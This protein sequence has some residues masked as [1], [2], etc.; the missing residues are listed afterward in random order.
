[1]GA[2][3]QTIATYPQRRKPLISTQKL[4]AN[5]LEYIIKITE[6]G[7]NVWQRQIDSSRR[8]N[9][10]MGRTSSLANQIGAD[11]FKWNNIRQ[12]VEGIQQAMDTITAPAV[13]FE[14]A[15]AELEGITGVTGKTLEEITQKSRALASTFGTDAANGASTFTEI[16]SRLGTDISKS[17]Q[18]LDAMGR[19]TMILSKTMQG[20]V[21]GAVDALTTSM[22]Q[23]N[24]SLA[25]PVKASQVM[26]TQMNILA[27]G[28]VLGSAKVEQVAQSIKVA[29]TSAYNSGVGFAE[30]NAAIQ[31]L[32]KGAMY[33]SEAGTGLR[34]VLNKLGEGRFMP[35]ESR[36]G[37]QKAGVDMRILGDKTIPLAARLQELKKIQSDSALVTAVFGSENANA[38]NILLNNIDTLKGWTGEMV[39]TNAATKQA[40]TQMNTMAEVLARQKAKFQDL[41][42]SIYNYTK[43]ALPMLQATSQSILLYTQL[44]PALDMV[45]G[46]FINAMTTVRNFTTGLIMNGAQIL[47]SA[48]QYIYLGVQG[49]GSFIANIV[50]ATFAQM[51]FVASLVM[52][53]SSF[54]AFLQKG[55][56]M[57]RT[58]ALSMLTSGWQAV[59]TAA[60]YVFTSVVGLGSY[61]V[62][63]VTAT[64]AQW[65]L[66]VALNA[67]PIGL[68]VLGLLAVG[69]AIFL[70]IKNWD[71]LK[72]WIVGLCNWFIANNPFRILYDFIVT[73]FPGIKTVLD[74]LM[75]WIKGWFDTIFGWLGSIWDTI[76]EITGFGGEMKITGIVQQ[77]GDIPGIGNSATPKGGGTTA[78]KDMKGQTETVAGGGTKHSNTYINIDTL[79]GAINNYMSNKEDMTGVEDIVLNA[80]TRVLTIAQS[81]AQ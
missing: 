12:S 80:I 1:M 53:P 30:A 63:L 47:K 10:T 51:K 35:K 54:F 3:F 56:T 19:S 49:V 25:D 14:S 59:K 79:V 13:K 6:Q 36:E 68:F 8:L 24:V 62:G 27:Q 21:A 16:L 66:N 5:I 60:Q 40:Q 75:T 7:A 32:G 46:G 78:P 57:T 2:N 74:G 31:V 28:A 64:A 70:I 61:I 22:L 41:G 72:G 77:T 45:K 67:N 58:F 9:D 26:N 4:M 15:M 76:K 34:N 18:A 69:T 55:I 17:P 11:F 39:N 50:R 33:G 38:A 44:A 71:T 37:L 43:G 42:I 20:N 48:A 23:Y 29:G 81:N 65:A 73:M 52:N